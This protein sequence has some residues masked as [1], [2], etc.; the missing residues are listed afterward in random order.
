MGPCEE[1]MLPFSEACERNKHPIL[2]VLRVCLAD[3]SQVLE[4]G[5]GS[6]QHAVHFARHLTH[7]TWQPTERLQALGDL[8]E[9]IQQEGSGNLR[10]PT[11][12]DVAQRLWPV[13]SVDAIFSAN[14]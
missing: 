6:G 13:K 8:T 3:R 5:S 14:T 12:L 2:E 11:V 1:P 10:P 4:V 9:R 7:L